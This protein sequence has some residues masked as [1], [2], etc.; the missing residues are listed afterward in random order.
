VAACAEP[1]NYQ[2]LWWNSPA[3]SES[4]WGINF[5][6]QG[7]QIFATWFTYDLAGKP[8]WLAVLA[9]KTAP[10]TYTG[11]LFVTTGPA[12]N[13][14][15]FDP[16]QV[17]ETTVGTATFTFTDHDNGKFDYTVNVPGSKVIAVQSKNITRQLFAAPVPTCIW[18]EGSDLTLAT[19]Y[20]DLWWRAPASLES[21]WGI[22]FTHQGHLIF[23]TW[24]TY[25]LA[26]KPWW[27]AILATKTGPTTYTGDLFT[28]VGPAFN[29]VPFNP[30]LVVETTVG[31]GTFTVVDGN[32][33]QFDYTVNGVAQTKP[34]TRQVF[35]GLGTP[36]RVEVPVTV[37]N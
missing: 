20:Q 30:A 8:W 36:C 7:D 10:N 28:T 23:A 17:T 3:S 31:T 14:V 18:S 27:L 13:A 26:G 24:F 32:N 19:N 35:A 37:Q 29:A 33:V 25:D 9:S 4:G 15:P 34:L 16:S 2:G 5:A 22:N 21:G 1:P 6:H 11:D 12:F